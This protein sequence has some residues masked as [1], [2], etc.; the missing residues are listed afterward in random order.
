MQLDMNKFRQA[1]F[2][3]VTEHLTDIDSAILALENNPNDREATAQLFRSVHSIK[4]ASG[5]LGFEKIESF[6][7]VLESLLDYFREGRL[8]ATADRLDLLRASQERLERLV[9]DARKGRQTQ[10]ESDRVLDELHRLLKSMESGG[11]HAKPDPGW[12]L[13]EA[14]TSAKNLAP[15]QSAMPQGTPFFGGHLLKRGLVTVDQLIDALNYQKIS[16]PLIGQI[17]LQERLLTV[18]QVFE[19]L[20]HLKGSEWRFGDAAVLLGFLTPD[21]VDCLLRLQRERTLTLGQILVKQGI[22]EQT[23]L[24]TEHAAYQASLNGAKTAD[25]T[26]DLS[27]SPEATPAPPAPILDDPDLLQEFVNESAEHLQH[28]EQYLMTIETDPRHS[29][30]LN[31]LYRA[32][33]TIKGVSSFLNLNDIQTLAH[34]TETLLNEAREHRVTLAGPTLEVCF[35]SVDTLKRYVGDVRERITNPNHEL[36]VDKSLPQLLL[37]IEQ[38]SRGRLNSYTAHPANS[39]KTGGDGEAPAHANADAK[40]KM[41]VKVDRDRLDKLVNAIGELVIA[42]AMVRQEVEQKDA[43]SSHGARSLPA[44]HKITRELQEQSLSLRMAPLKN[45]FQRMGRLVRDLAKKLGKQFRFEAEG[46]DT[47]LDKTLVDQIGDPL[48]HMIRNAADHGIESVADRLKAGKPAEGTIRLR[49]YHRSGNTYIELSDDG[50]GLHRETILAKAVEKGLVNAN[51]QLA[52]ESVYDLIFAPGFSTASKVTDVSGRGVGM[53]VVRRNVE[54]LS[55]SVQIESEFG[56]GTTFRIRLPL[57]LSI[58]DGLAVKSG[59][60]MFIV[61]LLSVIESLRPKATD[62]QSVLGK[63]EVITVRGETMPMARLS[64][65]FGTTSQVEDVSHGLV[66]IVENERK[67]FGLLVDELTGLPQVVMKSLEA[68]YRKVQGISGATILGDGRVALILD[69][70]GLVR[71]A[72]RMQG[73]GRDRPGATWAA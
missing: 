26:I 10:D 62:V 35:V 38:A 24:E 65:V 6:G 17:A 16:R 2:E 40:A 48:V 73:G 27:S 67:K 55:G 29:D 49:A 44:L 46:E 42:E 4:G 59:N 53:D 54:A 34:K 30:S 56:K 36:P 71:L 69:V 63:G 45:T 20:N 23:I 58:I 39:E 5:S 7:H 31:G 66:V 8:S 43:G 25:A 13:F 9:E 14:P 33:H 37:A 32:F 68:N 1:Y 12:G 21:A 50:R 28:A 51:E 61:P 47:E 72:E 11:D 15:M 64:H 18:K 19:T 70:P 60:E 3:E 52:D 41:T 22:L 57:T